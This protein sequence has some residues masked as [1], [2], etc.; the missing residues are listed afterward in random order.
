MLITEVSGAKKETW[1]SFK[2]VSSTLPYLKADFAQ[3]TWPS[4]RKRTCSQERPISSTWLN[5]LMA[6]AA[7]AGIVMPLSRMFQK[8]MRERAFAFEA[9]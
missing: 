7:V 5:M 4:H 6:F 8:Q 3:V 2:I 9:A 1:A